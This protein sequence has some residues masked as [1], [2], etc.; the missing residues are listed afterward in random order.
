MYDSIRVYQTIFKQVAFESLDVDVG[1]SQGYRYPLKACPPFLRKEYIDEVSELEPIFPNGRNFDYREFGSLTS[2][3]PYI[4]LMSFESVKS[5]VYREKILIDIGANGFSASPKQLVDNYAAEGLLFDKVLMFEPDIDNMQHGIDFYQKE[6]NI[7]FH[8]Q[9]I[10]I[11]TRNP[12]NDVISFL[13]KN[14]HINDF[15][16][17]KFDVDEGSN[18]PTMEWGF[19]ADLLYSEEIALVDEFYTELHFNN[20]EI[21]WRHQTHSARQRYDVVRQLRACGMAIHDWP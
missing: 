18:G 2:F 5:R 15:V 6:M 1:L 14:V 9:F 4:T 20:N 17:L 8:K 16:V 11:G 19:L 13:K 12:N 21:R 7:T 3:N 10:K